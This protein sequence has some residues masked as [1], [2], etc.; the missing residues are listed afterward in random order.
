MVV[1]VPTVAGL[2]KVRMRVLEPEPFVSGMRLRQEPVGERRLTVAA[3]SLAEG[4]RIDALPGLAEGTWVSML[5]RGGSLVPLR[6]TTQILAGDEVL[7]LV[8]P[9]QD[10]GPVVELFIRPGRPG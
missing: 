3:G 5:R 10:P 7:I 4:R 6:G 9:E 2:L 1:L 8:D